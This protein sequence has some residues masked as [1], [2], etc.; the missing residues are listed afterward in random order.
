MIGRKRENLRKKKKK[1]AAAND[2]SGDK[3]RV[4]AR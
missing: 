4:K 2:S 1:E 3:D